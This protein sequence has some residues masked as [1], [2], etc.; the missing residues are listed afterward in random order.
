MVRVA[1][2]GVSGA[3]GA[4]GAPIGYPLRRQKAVRIYEVA[5]PPR[6]VTPATTSG[7]LVPK[8]A[9]VLAL[10]ALAAAIANLVRQQREA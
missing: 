5:P 7:D 3:V 6:W 4:D 1:N 8:V 2:G 9:G 10:L